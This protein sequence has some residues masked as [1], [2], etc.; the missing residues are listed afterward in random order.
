[1]KQKCPCCGWELEFQ[2]SCHE[3]VPDKYQ[4]GRVVCWF[5][6]NA[7]DLPRI[8]AAMKPEEKRNA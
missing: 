4:C 8:S 6:C 1:M 5:G 3:I 7:E 2:K